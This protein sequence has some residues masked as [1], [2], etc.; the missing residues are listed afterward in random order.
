MGVNL[1]VVSIAT[2]EREE[3]IEKLYC[4][5][6][7]ET[8]LRDAEFRFTFARHLLPEKRTGKFKFFTNHMQRE[9]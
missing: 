7:G 6:I 2:D 3:D 8:D 1:F 5:L 9:V 4:Y